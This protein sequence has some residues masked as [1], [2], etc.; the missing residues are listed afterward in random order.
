MMT[1]VTPHPINKKS[2]K[3]CS[4][5]LLNLARGRAAMVSFSNV[6]LDRGHP[7]KIRNALSKSIIPSPTVV[8]PVKIETSVSETSLVAFLL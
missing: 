6:A 1:D 3:I 5:K 4:Y 8:P 2:N 7:N